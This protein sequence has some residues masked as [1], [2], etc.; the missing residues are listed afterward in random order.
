MKTVKKK[1]KTTL[2]LNHNL[3]MMFISISYF[4][5]FVLVFLAAV[6]LKLLTQK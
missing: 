6:P 1:Q 2:F 5:S 4:P 3:I